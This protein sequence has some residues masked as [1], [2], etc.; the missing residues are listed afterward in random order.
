MGAIAEAFV[1]YAQP[2]LDFLPPFSALGWR[3][4]GAQ[5]QEALPFGPPPGSEL[6]SLHS[7][8]ALRRGQ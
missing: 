3:H 5:R 4:T 7:A 6:G 2:L 1:S 8:L